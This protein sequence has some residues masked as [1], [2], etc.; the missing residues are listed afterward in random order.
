VSRKDLWDGLIDVLRDDNF[1][2]NVR[3]QGVPLD[4]VHLE[5]LSQ[6]LNRMEDKFKRTPILGGHKWSINEAYLLS[7][8][9]IALRLED[10]HVEHF[11]IVRW[12]GEYLALVWEY[13]YE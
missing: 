2:L 4:V 1:W 10:G 12:D 6:S 3:T 13:G 5:E 7:N 11:A 9:V 8:G